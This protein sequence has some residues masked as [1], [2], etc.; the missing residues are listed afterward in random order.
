MSSQRAVYNMVIAS[1]YT[2]TWIACCVIFGGGLFESHHA[3]FNGVPITG[4]V[5]LTTTFLWNKI[6]NAYFGTPYSQYG[7]PNSGLDATAASHC[8]DASIPLILTTIFG[9]FLS[10]MGIIFVA[11]RAAD[12]MN[13]LPCFNQPDSFIL[14]EF[15]NSVLCF[16]LVTIANLLGWIGCFMWE[17]I[18]DSIYTQWVPTGLLFYIICNVF[19]G[20]NVWMLMQ[21]RNNPSAFSGK[22]TS[23]PNTGAPVSYPQ[24]SSPQ[25]QQYAA[26]APQQ[27]ASP[28][29]YSSGYA[30]SGPPTH[31]PPQRSQQ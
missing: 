10:T 18:K 17:G 24:A 8:N 21:I 9:F 14:M 30:Q 25:P 13:C 26:S 29:P 19:L 7:T 3:Y 6:S 23:R 27:Y 4:P 15:V 28:A 31:Q 16:L 2:L 12:K 11:L 22:G 1:F 20:C 5:S